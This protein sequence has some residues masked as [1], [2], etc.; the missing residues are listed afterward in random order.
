MSCTY[1]RCFNL[2]LRATYLVFACSISFIASLPLTSETQA[3][4]RSVY[5]YSAGAQEVE[6]KPR[7]WSSGGVGASAYME[8]IVWRRW[9]RSVARGMG[10]ARNNDCDPTCADGTLHYYPGRLTLSRLR[11][12]RTPGG[13]KLRVYTRARYAMLLPA[14][15]P[16]RRRAGWS[17]SM[18]PIPD[19]QK[20]R[21]SRIDRMPV[22]GQ[23]RIRYRGTLRSRPT[24]LS[25]AEFGIFDETSFDAAGL[26]WTR[27][28]AVGKGVGQITHCIVEYRPCET[29]K[30]NVQ[31]GGL[32]QY[33]CRSG[34]TRYE[35]F[36]RIRFS[37]MRSDGLADSSWQPLPC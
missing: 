8:D 19:G 22:R 33:G 37:V 14:D 1:D 34:I 7:N 32:T 25:T 6:R 10:T 35:R 12:C 2:K 28:S 23:P 31:L 26:T 11:T 30:G 3:A 18:F 27:W 36:T 29:R 17:V 24:T 15:N 5:T 16:F 9:G 21:R 13:D 20:C 4:Q